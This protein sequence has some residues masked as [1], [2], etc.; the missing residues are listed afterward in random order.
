[1]RVQ[2][3]KG[4][5]KRE[6]RGRERERERERERKR[7]RARASVLLI[8]TGVP[9]MLLFLALPGQVV[10]LLTTLYEGNEEMGTVV[11]QG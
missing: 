5:K 4:W 2:L 9:E 7:E 8:F 3:D 1:M 6:N 11:S 10:G